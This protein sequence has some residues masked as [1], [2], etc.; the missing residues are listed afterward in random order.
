MAT[1]A[2]TLVTAVATC[3]YVAPLCRLPADHGTH[4]CLECGRPGGYLRAVRPSPIFSVVALGLAIFLVPGCGGLPRAPATPSAQDGFEPVE[5]PPGMDDGAPMGLALFPGDRVL[6]RMQSA[7]VSEVGPLLVDE[8][9]VIHVPL[10][11]D[12]NVG[13]T[14]LTAAEQRIE[15]AMQEYDATVRVTILV[16]EPTGHMASVI[17]AVEA[18]GRYPVVPGMRVAD[19]VAAAGGPRADG[20]ASTPPADLAAARVIRDGQGLPISV[21]LALTGDPRHNVRVRPG[22]H[23]YVPAQREGMVTVIGEVNGGLIFPH[24]DGIRLSQA[25]GLAGGMTRDANGGDIRIVRGPSSNPTVYRAAMDHIVDG[26]HPDPMLAPGDIVFVGS[27]ALADFRDAMAA[28]APLTS[29]A[30]TTTV[31]VAAVTAASP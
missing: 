31:G 28:I 1:G 23:L 24:R 6:L 22:D 30:S 16:A 8:R 2:A 15:Q 18:Q 26:E 27:S 13:G 5:P 11:G 25:L 4:R 10:A 19:L 12:V 9:G 29:V 20:D 17:G 3:R 21:D 14:P 7:E